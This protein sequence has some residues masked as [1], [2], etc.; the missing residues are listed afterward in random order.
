MPELPEV[1][2]IRLGLQKKIIGLKIS[3]IQILS[4]KSFIGNPNLASG[5]K[6]LNIWRIAKYLGMDLGKNTLLFHLKMTGQLIYDPSTS[7]RA[8]RFIGGHPTPDMRDQMPNSHTRV[9][10]SFSDGSH[11]Y[12]N[13]QRRFGW[14]RV[15]TST[16]VTSNKLFKNLGP[17]PL[18]KEFTWQILKQ[19]LL[20]HKSMSV[21]VVIMDQS[22]ISGVGN[23]YANEAC[24]LAG[25]DPRTKAGDMGDREFKAIHK[26]VIRAIKDGIKYG[27]ATR[28]H[29]VDAEGH[30][31]YFL[32]YAYVY[33][34]NNHRC[35]ACGTAIKKIQLGGRGTYFCPKCQKSI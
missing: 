33:G 15:V 35:K 19:N 32:D 30:K 20:R 17:E 22:V 28:V 10:F 1:E 18:E 23:I 34:R 9:I 7:L 3:K 29:F 24:F 8:R 27:G 16:E 14:V 4:P 21:K 2:T 25:I 12:F 6:V 13:D 31:G 26:G 5:R 11:L